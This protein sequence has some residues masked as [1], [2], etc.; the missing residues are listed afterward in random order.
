MDNFEA[1]LNAEIVEV[2]RVP[3]A[4]IV[5]RTKEIADIL[6]D[7]FS[8][9]NTLTPLVG[10]SY[11]VISF[12]GELEESGGFSLYVAI[13]EDDRSV[14]E[15]LVVWNKSKNIYISI[16]GTLDKADF[17]YAFKR[18]DG[19]EKNSSNSST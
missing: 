7:Y 13:K 18:G 17:E 3:D 5:S 11:D 10:T 12:N 6:E 19:N 16:R 2:G 9:R 14:E 4:R 1:I 15:E 8:D